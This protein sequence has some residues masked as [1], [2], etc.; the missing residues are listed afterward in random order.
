MVVYGSSLF[1]VYEP[2]DETTRVK[3][4][5]LTCASEEVVTYKE[6][7]WAVQYKLLN[8]DGSVKY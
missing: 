4:I 3:I 8:W 1:E 5:G 6:I 2:P 7:V